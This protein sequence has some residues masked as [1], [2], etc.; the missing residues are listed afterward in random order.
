MVNDVF[1]VDIVYMYNN[2]DVEFIEFCIFFYF[3]VVGC[4]IFF[5]FGKLCDKV[6]SYIR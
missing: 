3:I 1:V 4:I 5:M 2:C 6:F